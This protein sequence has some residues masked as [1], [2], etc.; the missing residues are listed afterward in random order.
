MLISNIDSGLG[1]SRIV[2][3]RKIMVIGGRKGEKI[4]R[5]CSTRICNFKYYDKTGK[6]EIRHCGIWKRPVL[7]A[8]PKI[9]LKLEGREDG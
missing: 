4:Q 6:R 7:E 2:I 3:M 9:I 1:P 5:A 8:M